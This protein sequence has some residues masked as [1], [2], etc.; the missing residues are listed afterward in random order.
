MLAGLS[1]SSKQG[2]EATAQWYMG[3]LKRY[4]CWNMLHLL[5]HSQQ[6]T[7]PGG[8]IDGMDEV[9]IG[10]GLQYE[11]CADWLTS[12]T[13]PSHGRNRPALW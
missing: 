10:L 6:P 13:W 5:C 7:R 8:R 11:T 4:Q 1:G 2:E 12:M 9:A 3:T